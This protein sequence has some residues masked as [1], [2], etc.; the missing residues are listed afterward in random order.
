MILRTKYRKTAVIV[1]V[2]ILYILYYFSNGG[3]GDIE[4]AF[5]GSPS[6]KK[7]NTHFPEE[8]KVVLSR[9]SEKHTIVMF[10]DQHNWLHLDINS[11]QCGNCEVTFDRSKITDPAT[12]AVVFHFN[13]IDVKYLQ[14]VRRLDQYYI[15]H[16]MESPLALRVVR[17][18]SLD[19]YNNFFNLTMS[20]R[21]DSDIYY[22]YDTTENI[23]HLLDAKGSG[24]TNKDLDQLLRKKKKMAL[25]V[26]SNCGTTSPARDRWIYSENL[27]K[28]G[29]ELDRRGHC[30]PDAPR[31]PVRSANNDQI[32]DDYIS[33]YKFY[34][35]FEN[36]FNCLDYITEKV[37]DNCLL[38]GAVP[39]VL[40]AKKS[41]Y[42]KV[43]PTDSFIYA[44]DFKSPAELVKYLHYLDKND[45]AYK[46]YFNWRVRDVKTMPNY[47]RAFGM[48][49]LCRVLHGINVDNLFHPYY[50]QYYSDIP[51]CGYPK[52]TRIVTSIRN[53]FYGNDYNECHANA[54]VLSVVQNWIASIWFYLWH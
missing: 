42:Q 17:G 26:T 38:H 15:W 33:E 34:M 27:I 41:D 35:A 25:W 40:G 11:D 7:T 29:L 4:P 51:L 21:D 28:A 30:F 13:Q 52:T 6:L 3:G 18:L 31:P 14:K 50:D 47:G 48:C 22:P 46:Q 53:W 39:V 24:D 32:W 20:Y 23:R 37:F 10:L 43:I 44:P 5:Q 49:Q 1:A 12:K 45:S 16:S 2:S 9:A 8:C 19:E 36:S 54:H